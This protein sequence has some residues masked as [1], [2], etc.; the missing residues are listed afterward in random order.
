VWEHVGFS[1]NLPVISAPEVR[2]RDLFVD[3]SL[4]DNL[5]VGAMADMGE[6]PIIAVDVKPTRDLEPV[7]DVGTARPGWR[8][9]ARDAEPVGERPARTPMLTETLARVLLLAS[10]DTVQAAERHADLIIR[11]RLAGV[12]L[13]E[14][15]QLDVAREAGRT[16]ARDALDQAGV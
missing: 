7:R 5:P 14:F 1:M 15:H 8:G 13:L 10:E 6:G 9:S 3:G 2:G 11:P 16:A 4:V 12:G